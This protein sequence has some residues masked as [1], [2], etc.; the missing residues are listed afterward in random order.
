M[1][2]QITTEVPKV[3]KT[4]SEVRIALK[5]SKKH[6]TSISNNSEVTAG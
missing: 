3:G 6:R 4:S 5:H 2:C 1:C